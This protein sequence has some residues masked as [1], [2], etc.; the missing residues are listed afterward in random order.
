M[1]GNSAVN[2]DEPGFITISGKRFKLRMGLWEILTLK[3]VDTDTIPPNDMKRHK[4]I[5]E[6]TNAQLTRYKPG[7]NKD[8]SRF[9]IH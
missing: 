9:E 7:G 8:L 3:D 2:L 1:I 6:M 5:L 4:S